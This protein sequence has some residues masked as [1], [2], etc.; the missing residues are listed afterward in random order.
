MSTAELMAILP[1]LVAVAPSK[2]VFTGG[3]PL[4]RGDL[5]DL[6]ARLRELDRDHRVI[7]CVNTNGL[8]MTRDV[9]A[10]LVGLA[11]EVRVSIDALRERNDA[12]RGAGSF[13]AAVGALER[14][15]A[16][17]FEPKALVTVTADTLPDLPA[18]V[19][20][21]RARGITRV[22]VN[23]LRAI[24]RGAGLVH[25]RP[26]RADVAAALRAAVDAPVAVADGG[27]GDGGCGAGW[28]L[29]IMPDGAVY[30]CH[31]LTDAA[32]ACGH[33]RRQSLREICA[34]GGPLA[35][36]R[37]LSSAHGSQCLGEAPILY[38]H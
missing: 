1:D 24:G 16:A 33:L 3:E 18:L 22:N 5:L 25:L 19:A 27:D 17:G 36:L 31:V 2:V 20:L 15:H 6:L 34:A 29:N 9:A 13:D 7:R 37:A 12:A 21:L 23:P 26:R 11:D 28:F 14:L 32:F 8:R 10:A 30:P 38:N 4:L 35:R